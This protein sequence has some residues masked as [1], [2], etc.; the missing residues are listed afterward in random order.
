MKRR[1]HFRAFF[2]YRSFLACLALA[3]LLAVASLSSASAQL[4]FHFQYGRL[5]NPFSGD[6][7]GTPI[8]TIQ[9]ASPWRLGDSFFFLDYLDDGMDDGF[10]D[11]TFYGEWYPTLS[12]GKLANRKIGVGRLRD[13][14]FIAGV[15]LETDANVLKYLPG[16][17]FS[18]DVPGFYFV[19]TDFMMIVDANRGTERGGAPSTDNGFGADINWGAGFSIGSQWFRFS[20]H[21]ECGGAVTNELGE[22]VKGWIL[23]QPQ[24]AWDASRLAGGDGNKLFVGVEYLYWRNKLGTSANDNVLQLLVIWAL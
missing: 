16:V 18:W 14:G 8:V 21:A 17:R 5:V 3:G 10:N 7:R 12:L 9:H 4:E 15:N 20:G 19:N 13:I 2:G 22:E 6:I 23:A 1:A 24:L 11:R